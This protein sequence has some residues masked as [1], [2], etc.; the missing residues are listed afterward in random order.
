MDTNDTTSTNVTNAHPETETAGADTPDLATS[1]LAVAAY[2]RVLPELSEV[3]DPLRI[4]ADIP[5]AVGIVF[6]V[7]PR[8]REL[9]PRIAEELPRF[10][11]ELIGK[12]PH[13]A[14]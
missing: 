3:T 2:T 14:L 10:P 7:M 9:E 1:E 6:R 8:L 4:A 11:R 5:R 13:Y 12:L